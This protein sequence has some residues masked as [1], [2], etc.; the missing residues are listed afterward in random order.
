MLEEY[1][2][3]MTNQ[4]YTAFFAILNDRNAEHHSTDFFEEFA[5][6]YALSFVK[7][8][9][10]EDGKW[11]LYAPVNKQRSE[12]IKKI[13]ERKNTDA[14]SIMVILLEHAIPAFIKDFKM[15]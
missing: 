8:L 11:V 5:D 7:N 10:A 13:K 2:K 14:M 12:V 4:F 3:D 9:G 1:L 15:K 6:G